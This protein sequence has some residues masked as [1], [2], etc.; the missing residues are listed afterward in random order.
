V[1]LEPAT[2]FLLV[3][4]A[5][6]IDRRF[7][8]GLRVVG[9]KPRELHTLR[10]LSLAAPLSQTELAAGL[11]VDAANLIDTI[12][13]LEAQGLI[14]R[15]IDPRDRRRRHIKLTALGSRRLHAGLKAAESAEQDV[16][17]RLDPRRSEQLRGLLLDV[18]TPLQQQPAREHRF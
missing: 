2:G 13:A 5:E 11:E 7:T 18:Y 10:Y 17:G 16:L 8:E 4:V 15:E 1:H 12:D 14:R 9:L 6:A 3:R